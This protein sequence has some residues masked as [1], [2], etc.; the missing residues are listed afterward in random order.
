MH[1]T[2]PLI[3]LVAALENAPRPQPGDPARPFSLP[4]SNGK[5]VQLSDYLGK[6]AVVLAFF[7]KAFTGG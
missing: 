4:A 1:A 3:L 2:V 6:K 5:N 7:P